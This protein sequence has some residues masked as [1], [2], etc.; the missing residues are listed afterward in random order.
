MDLHAGEKVIYE[1]HPSWRSTFGFY[2]MGVLLV[3]AAVAIGVV[4]GQTGI[5]LAAAAGRSS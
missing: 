1:G 4:A 3:A 5:G 2:L